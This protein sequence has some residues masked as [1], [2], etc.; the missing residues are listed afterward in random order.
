M[1]QQGTGFH[2]KQGEKIRSI[3]H[4]FYRCAAVSALFGILWPDGPGPRC[5]APDMDPAPSLGS[6]V[7]AGGHAALSPTA[8]VRPA[9][10][11]IVRPPSWNR[12]T[13]PRR[14]AA[15]SSSARPAEALSFTIAAFL[16]VT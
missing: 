15:L 13:S 1:A 3:C 8:P 2:P 12:E 11:S 10:V 4:E 5:T 6:V 9:M 7:P 16:C 14:R